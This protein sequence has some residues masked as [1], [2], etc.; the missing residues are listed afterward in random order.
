[1]LPLP[2]ISIRQSVFASTRFREFPRGPR[3][4]PTKLNWEKE[5]KTRTTLWVWVVI[6]LRLEQRERTYSREFVYRNINPDGFLHN[7]TR[8]ATFRAKPT[9][10]RRRLH[11]SQP[12]HIT[13]NCLNERKYNTHEITDLEMHSL[14]KKCLLCGKILRL[15]GHED[16]RQQCSTV[17]NK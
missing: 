11:Q 17:H 6:K 16:Q 9:M 5:E 7:K 10:C 14:L 13:S 3:S 15:D 1:M 2:L 12:L 4:R 8:G